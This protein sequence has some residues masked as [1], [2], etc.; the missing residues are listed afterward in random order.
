MMHYL[1]GVFVVLVLCAAILNLASCSS[2]AKKVKYFQNIPDSGA[3][4]DI[5]RIEY[6]EP[7]IQVDDILT[8]NVITLDPAALAT[9]NLGNVPSSS[10]GSLTPASISTTG[11]Q[12][13]A[14]YLVDKNG[15]VSIPVIG[16]VKV[17]GLTTAEARDAVSKAAKE[18]YKDASVIVRFAN[19]KITVAGEVARPSVY[20]V[21]NEK[22]T[23]LDA[24]GMAGDLTVFGKRDNV[25]LIRTLSDGTRELHRF[26]LNHADVLTSPYFYL[27]QN[28]YVYVQPSKGKAAATDASQTRT[29]AIVGSLLSV[30]IVIASRINF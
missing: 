10:T 1:K 29:Y 19:F 3:L 15:M 6:R 16:E 20:I 24:L 7:K 17:A 4:A 26:N 21:P 2:S 27:K 11:S 12:V 25:L 30:L 9:I 18:Y 14:G 23:L 8:I 22:V 13:V 5:P 28:D